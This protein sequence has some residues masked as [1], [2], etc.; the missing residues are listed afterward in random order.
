MSG[1]LVIVRSDRGYKPPR[2]IFL[3]FA[4]VTIGLLFLLREL[5]ALPDISF[6]TFLWLG[7]GGWLFIG[8]LAGNR[9]GW[10]WPF[11]LL[12]IGVFMLLRDL[13][14]IDRDFAVWPIVV[15]GL[16]LAMLAEAFTRRTHG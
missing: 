12:L 2:P 13:D 10:F 15:L 8:T 7:L 14:V 4:L 16:G 5:G 9:R 3:G 11:T 1:R 6:W